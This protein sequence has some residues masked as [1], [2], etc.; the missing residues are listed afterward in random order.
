MKISRRDAFFLIIAGGLLVAAVPFFAHMTNGIPMTPSPLIDDL[1]GVAGALL[2][3]S[4]I[5]YRIAK[6][7]C[8]WNEMRYILGCAAALGLAITEGFLV[9]IGDGIVR[10]VILLPVACFVIYVSGNVFSETK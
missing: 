9:G 8:E 5:E 4:F 3:M 1:A 7:S 2:I 6:R 10:L